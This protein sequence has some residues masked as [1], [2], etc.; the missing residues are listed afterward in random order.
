MS[1]KC[2][3]LNKRENLQIKKTLS[4]LRSDITTVIS[5]VNVRKQLPS[6]NP[7]VA[8]FCNSIV[9][10]SI[11]FLAEHLHQVFVKLYDE[12]S[13]MKEKYLQFQIKWH[14]HCSYFLVEK[15]VELSL[16]GLH[17]AE[18]SA[19]AVVSV[20]SQWS[21]LCAANHLQRSDAKIFM[22]LFC[23]CPYDELLRQYHKII[24]PDVHASK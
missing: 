14:R 20:R 9:P 4:D 18:P 7:T 16:I 21:K 19:E 3:A 1:R 6:S 24:E 12:C 23:G 15:N 10:N 8:V 17:S 2:K 13:T 22:I 5:L 11:K